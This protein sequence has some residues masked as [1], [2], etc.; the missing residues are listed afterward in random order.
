[1][2]VLEPQSSPKYLVVDDEI[3]EQSEKEDFEDDTGLPVESGIFIQTYEEA[4]EVLKSDLN[5]IL[6]FI[7]IRIPRNKRDVYEKDD[8]KSEKWSDFVKNK[9]LDMKSEYGAKILPQ[10]NNIKTVIFSAYADEDSLRQEAERY[11]YVIDYYKKPW[12]VSNFIK[13]KP[14]L[15][16]F[17]K[18]N[19]VSIPT[20]S[21]DYSSFNEETVLFVQSRAVEI[22]K[23]GRR[24]T[25]DIISIGNYLIEVKDKL[26]HG[27]FRDWLRSE[28][29][30][31]S[32]R[33][34]GRFMNVAK[35]FK[36][37]NLSHL[38]I[39]PSALYELSSRS[40]PE[41]AMNEALERAERGET[42]T[43]QIAKG[44]KA[45][46]KILEEEKVQPQNTQN[47]ERVITVP[48]VSEPSSSLPE[49]DRPKQEILGVIPS[50]NAV[51]NSWW[52]LGEHNRLFCG[53]P[54]DKGFL[55][56]LPKDIALDLSFLPRKDFSLIPAIESIISHIIILRENNLELGTLIE[57]C[58]RNGT[59]SKETIVFSY[60]Y[61]PQLLKIAEKLD[62]YFWAAEPDLKKCEQILTIWREKGSVMR[63]A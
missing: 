46:Y 18:K 53:E 52:Q 59:S 12:L 22:K 15:K 45:K 60:V 48:C 58:I 62:C 10:I 16:L 36:S 28:F 14:Y 26:G 4:L 37:V 1:M 5:I 2:R 42:I 56:N 63:I 39:L 47:R 38:E 55:K 25:E 27:Y 44:L 9:V 50:Q 24:A 33:T 49:K 13:I 8:G 30:W 40:F 20:I 7:D 57:E 29:G 41:E 3:V 21:F 54:K 11:P 43:D 32:I 17:P 19:P 61:Y 51:K 23:L 34:A 35:R 31:K 6:C